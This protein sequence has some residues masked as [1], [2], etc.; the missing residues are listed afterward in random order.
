MSISFQA[1]CVGVFF[2]KMH[3]TDMK[4]KNGPN[5]TV[6]GFMVPRAW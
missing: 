4:I 1:R 2:Q 3:I 6:P 5:D